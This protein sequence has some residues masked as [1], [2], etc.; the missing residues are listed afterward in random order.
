MAAVAKGGDLVTP[1][2]GAIIRMAMTTVLLFVCIKFTPLKEGN[3]EKNN[4]ENRKRCKKIGQLNNAQII[5]FVSLLVTCVGDIIQLTMK[6]AETVNTIIQ[7]ISILLFFSTLLYIAKALFSKITDMIKKMFVAGSDALLEFTVDE[8]AGDLG[9]ILEHRTLASGDKDFV[10]EGINEKVAAKSIRILSIGKN[11]VLLKEEE[12]NDSNSASTAINIKKNL[13]YR[14]IFPGF[15]NGDV[16]K[17]V[18]NLDFFGHDLDGNDVLALILTE[19]R[20]FKVVV[21][22]PGKTFIGS[23]FRNALEEPLSKPELYFLWIL[24]FLVSLATIVSSIWV[25][26]MMSWQ[27]FASISNESLKHIQNKQ[28]AEAK[29]KRKK[30]EAMSIFGTNKSNQKQREK[31]NSFFDYASYKIIFIYVWI[32]SSIAALINSI[33]IYLPVYLYVLGSCLFCCRKVKSTG[34]ITFCVNVVVGSL[35]FPGIAIFI[36]IHYSHSMQ[37]LFSGNVFCR[38]ILENAFK[39]SVESIIFYNQVASEGYRVMVLQKNLV[40]FAWDLGI[41]I[42]FKFK[43]S[44][45]KK[46]SED[47]KRAVKKKIKPT[48]MYNYCKLGDYYYRV[49]LESIGYPM[50]SFVLGSNWSNVIN[51]SDNSRYVYNPETEL[52]Q[53]INH[54]RM[55]KFNI[56]TLPK[57]KKG[58]YCNICSKSQILPPPKEYLADTSGATIEIYQTL[59]P[60]NTLTRLGGYVRFANDSNGVV[61]YYRFDSKSNGA[62]KIDLDKVKPL[63]FKGHNYA[64]DLETLYIY[65]GETR[66]TYQGS[67]PIGTDGALCIYNEVLECFTLEDNSTRILDTKIN[68]QAYG[69]GSRNQYIY[70]VKTRRRYFKTISIADT[71]YKYDST[72]DSLVKAD[73]SSDSMQRCVFQEQVYFIDMKIYPGDI[74][75]YEVDTNTM[76]NFGQ[77]ILCFNGEKYNNYKY[78]KEK[79]EFEI[80]GEVDVDLATSSMILLHHK[81]VSYFVDS[82]SGF[83][84]DGETMDCYGETIN[85]EDKEYYY[86]KTS[87]SFE[88]DTDAGPSK[89]SMIQTTFRGTLYYVDF[90]N[91]F[92]AIYDSKTMKMIG[93]TMT[94]DGAE[95]YYDED[96]GQIVTDDVVK[97]V[98]MD[99]NATNPK[100]SAANTAW[101]EDIDKK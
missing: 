75:Y 92:G 13:E 96:K 52:L 2:V 95:Y 60:S 41:K 14:K 69:I 65:D 67:A 38:R 91:S 29:E 34:T 80:T 99:D 101:S 51:Y 17:K 45:P 37:R 57:V 100:L 61:E 16:I 23:S 56:E 89:S 31:W 53:K 43:Y 49:D 66:K 18:G 44:P 78:N 48:K 39:R 28:K 7:V 4:G 27:T 97:K 59:L 15:I 58:T 46:D 77:S 1:I 12:E 83:I 19:P 22:R 73:L 20:P 70:D 33:I 88:I 32:L 74:Y 85:V 93:E 86:E 40:Q 47:V 62:V 94:I 24:S 63:K 76:L 5:S 72:C 11:S 35:V 25:V 42:N 64:V 82:K 30:E 90:E 36:I 71:F 10:I 79:N 87:R 8:T 55:E 54:E 68:G 98:E 6:R 84:Y 81:G 21:L 50:T 26:I 3:S 9:F